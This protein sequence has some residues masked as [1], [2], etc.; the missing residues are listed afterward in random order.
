MNANEAREIRKSFGP[1]GCEDEHRCEEE[2]GQQ[3][4]PSTAAAAQLPRRLEAHEASQLE[5]GV[6]V[7]ELTGCC[8]N[9]DTVSL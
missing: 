2:R 5:N 6:V 8:C 7:C 1:P 4:A 3:A 9:D